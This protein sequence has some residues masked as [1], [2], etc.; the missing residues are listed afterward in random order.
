MSKVNAPQVAVNRVSTSN[1]ATLEDYLGGREVMR[2]PRVDSQEIVVAGA[3]YSLVD[4]SLVSGN[5]AVG[6]GTAENAGI[7]VAENV[8]AVGTGVTTSI[9][10]TN[11]NVLNLIDIVDADT[12]DP[13]L[14][15]N[16]R[17]VYGLLQCSNGVADG[18]AITASGSEN[19]QISYVIVD[20]NGAFA[21][22]TVTDTIEFSINK[23]FVRR[24]LPTIFLAGNPDDQDIIQGNT[25]TPKIA[26]FEITADYSNGE[27]ITLS[28]GTGSGTGTSTVT[29]KS[30]TTIGADSSTFNTTDTTHV[31]LNGVRQDKGNDVIWDTT[32]S[33]HFSF[34]VYTGD[35]F[36]VE[37]VE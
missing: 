12:H 5:L 23:V 19:T 37:V 11:G 27:V 35:I 21:L 33:L 26:K 28:T 10:D 16:G 15:S 24:Q 32:G 9:S 36:E 7:V 29:G 1:Y 8:G 25:K 3:N 13:L 6:T 22:T 18:T 31:L 14:D 34:A 30:L 2:Q 20:Q 17:K 4:S